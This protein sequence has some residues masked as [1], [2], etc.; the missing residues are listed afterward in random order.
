MD[1][2]TLPHILSG[3]LRERGFKARVIENKQVMADFVTNADIACLQEIY[4]ILAKG[5]G[6]IYDSRAL[7]P[8]IAVYRYL[9]DSFADEPTLPLCVNINEQHVTGNLSYRIVANPHSRHTFDAPHFV[10][11]F[12]YSHHVEQYRLSFVG[13]NSAKPLA[14]LISRIPV[15][16]HTDEHP[17]IILECV[18]TAGYDAAALGAAI[19]LRYS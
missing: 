12:E 14:R 8:L 4:G 15:Q 11:P 13:W 10:E 17:Q 1:L 5:L 9:R 2:S 7:P 3:H 16:L 18:P 19:A 6:T